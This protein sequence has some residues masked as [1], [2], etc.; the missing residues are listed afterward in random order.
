MVGDEIFPLKPWLMRPYPG[1]GTGKM[2]ESQKVYNYRQS[3]ARRVI[4]NAFGILRARWRIFSHPIKASV[5]NTEKYVIACLCL[6]NYLRQTENSLYT[7]Q[8]FVDL[9]LG[10]GEIK[11][12]EWRSHIQEDG[13]LRSLNISKGGR[14]KIVANELREDL[15]TFL[16]S[17]LGSVPWQ[18]YYV[19]YAG[20]VATQVSS[21]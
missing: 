19:R 12:G 9:E 3:R 10:N 13:C 14:R 20:K 16:N 7:P 17:E 5:E 1:T 21:E 4:E 2:S 6:H 8:G 18:L 11:V 15:K